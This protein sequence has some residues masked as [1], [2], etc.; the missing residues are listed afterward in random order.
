[1]TPA[2]LETTHQPAT[3]SV[4]WRGR[5]VVSIRDFDRKQIDA[6]LA[7]TERFLPIAAGQRRNT[8]LEGRILCTLFFEPSTR[9]RLSFEAAMQRLGGS[10]IGFSDPTQTSNKKGETLADTVRV[11]DGLCDALVLRHPKEGA[12]RLAA[13]YAKNPVINAGD[14]AGEHPT[15]TLLD[16]FTI[17]R[18]CKKIDGTTI[19]LLGDLKYGR[20][21]HSLVTALSHYS[22]RILLVSPPSLALPDEVVS[23]CRERGAKLEVVEDLDAVV[24]LADVLYVTR[25]QAERFVD[26]EEFRNVAGT[27]RISNQLLS[28]AKGNLVV[29]HPLPRVDEIHPE[30]DASP[31]ARYFQQASNGLA[32]RMALLAA[33]L[34][35]KP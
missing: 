5:D 21:V 25:I 1:M 18:E 24:P 22:C 11:V 13:E 15:Q 10:V 19:V 23:A 17:Q 26:P 8:S 6:F 4:D 31:H 20:T 28:K 16:L 30:V 29:L 33:I 9:T 32:V 2:N 3:A 27:Y 35:G 7:W 34:G 12:A 14:G